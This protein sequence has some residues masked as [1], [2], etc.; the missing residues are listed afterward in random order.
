MNHSKRV[1][2]DIVHQIV[3]EE[4]RMANPY[5]ELEK[6]IEKLNDIKPYL[7]TVA[8]E[9]AYTT[10]MGTAD[11]TGVFTARQSQV[12]GTLGLHEDEFGNPPLPAVVV[13]SREPPMVGEKYFN[14]IKVARNLTN[15]IP[16]TE[17]DKR[18]LWQQHIR[19]VRDYWQE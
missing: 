13:Q 10:Y 8:Q 17:S 12:L 1:N 15:D 11:K 4:E 2:P 19:D 14:M 3:V 18:E 5:S 9:E 7:I 6:L 16:E